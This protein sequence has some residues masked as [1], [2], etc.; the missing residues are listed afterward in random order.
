MQEGHVICYESKKLNRHEIHYVTHDL[1]LASIVNALKLWR[2]YLLGNKFVLMSDHSGLRY[3]FDHPKLN[4]RKDVWMTLL[5][6][7]DFK[8]KDTK[9]KQNGVVDSISG[10]MKVIH[11]KFVSN[12]ESYI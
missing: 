2:H 4:A 8:I 7:F 1:E 12:C 6:G 11:L 3:L 5:S 9:R 10:S